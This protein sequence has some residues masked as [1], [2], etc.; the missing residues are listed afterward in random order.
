MAT[1]TGFTAERMLEIED[2]TV[3]SGEINESGD[4]I[5]TT[6]GGSTIN[7]GPVLGTVPDASDTV[8]GIVEL[9]T[10]SETEALS[11]T[12]RAITPAGLASTISGLDGRLDV[13]EAAKVQ[14]ITAP[15]ESSGASSYPT[16]ISLASVSSGSGWSLNGGLGSIVTVKQS[17]DRCVQTFYS[18]N[19]GTDTPKS[20]FR[21][22]HSSGGGGGWTAWNLIHSGIA[23]INTIYPVGSIYMSTV[24]TNP[25]ILF[26]V[27][28]WAAI[29]GKFLI[30]ADGT[31]AAGSTG[32]SATATL[33]STELPAHTHSFSAST[34]SA[35][36]HAHQIGVDSIAGTGTG[37]FSVN[38]P[39]SSAGEAGTVTSFTTGAHSHT[40]SG[41]SGSSG[42]GSA[43]SILPPYLSVY[44]WK[45]TA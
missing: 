16:G 8:K 5:L 10:T 35:G 44:M 3:V 4:L 13:L 15:S 24:D 33:T 30:G 43:F 19:G 42:T 14:T 38:S 27:G 11:D 41:T 45:R 9:A 39:G 22:H 20:W 31:Y 6:H 25:N 26:G 21:T 29:E 2:G 17:S 36:D 23:I 18:N 12:T 32:G 1:V 34:N 28:T 37:E 40:V 7:A